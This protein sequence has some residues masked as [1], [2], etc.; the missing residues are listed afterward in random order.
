MTVTMIRRITYNESNRRIREHTR[1]E[2]LSGR[3]G[4]SDLCFGSPGSCGFWTGKMMTGFRDDNPV[5]AL[6][7]IK[8]FKLSSNEALLPKS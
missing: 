7:W 1:A 6:V 2:Q 8:G 4:E 5:K 3:E